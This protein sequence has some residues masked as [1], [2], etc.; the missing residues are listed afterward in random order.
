M[1]QMYFCSEIIR[2][3]DLTNFFRWLRARPH[4]PLKSLLSWPCKKLHSFYSFILSN[5]VAPKSVKLLLVLLLGVPTACTLHFL[6]LSYMIR[7]LC[8]YCSQYKSVVLD[9]FIYWSKGFR[10]KKIIV[11]ITIINSG[12]KSY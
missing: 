3:P 6:Y 2:E 1:L 9:C 8:F 10:M 4:Y 5:N 12:D 11:T 7:S